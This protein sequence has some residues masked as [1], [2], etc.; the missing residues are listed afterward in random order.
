MLNA[1]YSRPLDMQD[2]YY[3]D[4]AYDAMSLSSYFEKARLKA[5]DSSA[6]TSASKN[7]TEWW[8]YGGGEGSSENAWAKSFDKLCSGKCKLLTFRLYSESKKS[9]MNKY[10]YST[11]NSLAYNNSL[12]VNATALQKMCDK[13][14][15]KLT[16]VYR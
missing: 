11:S 2:L 3:S 4:V 8:K 1:A 9:K 6:V 13:Y 15:E 5:E 14:P 10:M 16:E 7:I 12:I